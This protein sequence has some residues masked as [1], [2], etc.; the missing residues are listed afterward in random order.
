MKKFGIITVLILCSAFAEY[1]REIGLDTLTITAPQEE[2]HGEEA[3]FYAKPQEPVVLRYRNDTI[4][5]GFVRLLETDNRIYLSEGFHTKYLNNS[6]SGNSIEYDPNSNYIDANNI[7]ISTNDFYAQSDRLAFHGD[8]ISLIKSTIGLPVY[9]FAM[10]SRQLDIYPGWMVFYDTTFDWRDRSYWYIPVYVVDQRRNAFQ[11]PGAFPRTGREYFA[12]DFLRWNSHYYVSDQ[13]YGNAQVGYAQ[14]KGYGYGIQHIM[15]FSESD[16]MMYLNE[17]WQYWPTKEAIAYEHSFL[18]PASKQ[19]K[20]MNFNELLQYNQEVQYADVS[21]IFLRHTVY[22]ESGVDLINRNFELEYYASVALPWQELKLYTT[23]TY[24]SIYER[25]TETE[26][27]RWE[28]YNELSRSFVVPWD[29]TFRPGVGYDTVKYSLYPYNWHRIFSFANFG[30]KFWIFNWNA[31]YYDYLEERGQSPFSYD[32]HWE[33]GDNI[34]NTL[35]MKAGSFLFGNRIQY[36]VHSKSIYRCW[37]YL[38]Y[39]SRPW[40]I[41]IERNETDDSWWAGISAAF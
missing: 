37:Y 27:R 22:E 8:K 36:L 10:K 6:I 29:F 13:I 40:T 39:T 21:S 20:D 5:A 23:N 11:I 18:E 32:E 30:K 1:H 28:T 33:V 15:H 3:F 2:R 31:K 12:G 25:T 35:T 7:I 26:G 24:A 14:E 4:S 34:M 9:D 17:N 16:Q 19:L 41:R 38:E